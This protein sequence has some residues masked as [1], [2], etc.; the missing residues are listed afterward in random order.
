MSNLRPDA[1]ADAPEGFKELWPLVLRWGAR[2]DLD[3][4]GLVE[5]ASADE[6]RSLV[7]AITPAVFDAI[8][9]YS[10]GHTAPSTPF[11]TGTSLKRPWRPHSS[12]AADEPP[13]TPRTIALA[14]RRRSLGH[15]HHSAERPL[16]QLLTVLRHGILGSVMN[17][18]I[19][20]KNRHNTRS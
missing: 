16:A 7:A 8:N 11:R 3:H 9:T 1:P 4:E 12:L 6:P 5:R 10:D 19:Q 2:D 20:F 17:P 13:G 15:R 18:T 14:P